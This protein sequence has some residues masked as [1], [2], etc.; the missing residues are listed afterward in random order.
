MTTYSTYATQR[1]TA[2]S[3][4]SAAVTE[5]IAAMTDLAA[6]DAVVINAKSLTE[7]APFP[8]GTFGQQARNSWQ[9]LP[10]ILTHADF[11]VVQPQRIADAVNAAVVTY[12]N[13]L[14]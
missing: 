12:V 14:T 10:K 9:D 8:V 13:A 3:R 4:Y 1:S 7:G 5:L 11:C 6:L 2:G